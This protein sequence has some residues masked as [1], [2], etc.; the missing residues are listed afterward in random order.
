VFLHGF[1]SKIEEF[2][3]AIKLLDGDFSYLI[4]DLPGHGKTQVY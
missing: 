3:E 4:L 2:D 1:I